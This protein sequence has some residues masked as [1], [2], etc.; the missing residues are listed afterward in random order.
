M[1]TNHQVLR[2]IESRLG[3]MQIPMQAAR[4][5]SLEML[6]TWDVRW[7]GSIKPSAAHKMTQVYRISC[8]SRLF[9]SVSWAKNHDKSISSPNVPIDVSPELGLLASISGDLLGLAIRCD[10]HVWIL[11]TSPP[12]STSTRPWSLF[13]PRSVPAYLESSTVLL[14]RFFSAGQQHH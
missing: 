1:A 3:P 7:I 14:C 6:V 2:I 4:S 10:I 11:S 5:R 9:C 13:F 12:P 8:L